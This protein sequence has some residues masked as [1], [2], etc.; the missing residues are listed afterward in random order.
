M[1]GDTGRISVWVG[2]TFVV[3]LPD[4]D[5]G[6]WDLSP[7]PRLFDPLERLV[8]GRVSPGGAMFFKKS[9]K[10]AVAVL[11]FPPRPSEA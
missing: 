2:L 7:M 4:V 10:S 1:A 9:A 11:L 8:T 6:G 3:E 5:S